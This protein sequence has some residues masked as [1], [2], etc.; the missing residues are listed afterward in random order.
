MHAS[1]L[2]SMLF[3]LP[4]VCWMSKPFCSIIFC[5]PELQHWTRWL[6]IIVFSEIIWFSHSFVKAKKIEKI[7][8]I[9][10]PFF[11]IHL[12]RRPIKSFT[13]SFIKN[14]TNCFYLVMTWRP[15][16]P[17]GLT[18]ANNIWCE[19]EFEMLWAYLCCLQNESV[20]TLFSTLVII[21]ILFFIKFMRVYT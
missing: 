17:C 18:K 9:Y 12:T 14:I 15:T 3:M 5:T 1:E 21:S 13:V 16:I 20:N 10:I 11:P 19:N 2:S 8:I 7:S 4:S 6:T